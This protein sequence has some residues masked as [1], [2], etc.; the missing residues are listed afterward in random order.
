MNNE[1]G[2]LMT[3]LSLSLSLG[4]QAARTLDSSTI[5]LISRMTTPPTSARALLINAAIVSLKAAGVWTKMDALWFFA[6][7]DS[8][9]ALLNWV[10]ASYTPS[11]V[12]APT[13]TAD[14][15]YAGNGTSSYL[16][17]TYKPLSN[18]VNYQKNSASFGVWLNAGTDTTS[19]G[20]AIGCSSAGF[21]SQCGIIPRSATDTALGYAN[22][23]AGSAFLSA[24][25]RLG[26]TATSRTGANVNYVYRNGVAGSTEI[27]ASQNAPD[28]EVYLCV[29]NNNGTPGQYLNNR[30]AF[31][32]LG[33]GLTDAEMLALYNAANTYLTAVGGQ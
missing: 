21:T 28:V 30:H 16:N 24:G 18:G 13:F 8:Q 33:G 32:F 9:A 31:A 25:T 20:I 5:S 15:G 2:N 10:S 19:S 3:G 6:A 27:A 7:A 12:N 4:E 26:F 29:R 1:G 22:S 14:R 11:L 23:S 17:T